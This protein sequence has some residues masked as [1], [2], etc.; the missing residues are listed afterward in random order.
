M[1]TKNKINEKYKAICNDETSDIYYHMPMLKKYADECDL[2]YELGV[3]AVCSSWAI[4]KSLQGKRKETRKLVSI[5]KDR[6]DQVSEAE[7]IAKEAGVN[8]EFIQADDLSIDIPEC[9]MI[10]FDTQHTYGQVKAELQ[11]HGNKSKKYLVFHDVK[12]YG[13][14]GDDGGIGIMPAIN[15]FM[16]ANPQWIYE[17]Q[18]DE[19]FGLLI[20][21][22]R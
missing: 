9:D 14:K 17:Y 1:A 21:I 13:Q 6:W 4:L 11:K 19:N 18:T 16:E 3:R 8:W 2:I 15:E 7:Q 22:R 20:L 10:F 5:D 12:I